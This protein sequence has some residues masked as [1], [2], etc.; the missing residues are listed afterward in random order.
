MNFRFSSKVAFFSGDIGSFIN[1]GI[2]FPFGY[3]ISVTS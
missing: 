3:I 2:I 1:S